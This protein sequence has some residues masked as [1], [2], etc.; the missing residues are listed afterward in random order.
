[1]IKIILKIIW[2]ILVVFSFLFTIYFLFHGQGYGIEHLKDIFSAGFGE[3]IK[4]FFSS[5]WNGI[6]FVCGIN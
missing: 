5:I 4:Q 2:Y 1:M 6:K 3:G